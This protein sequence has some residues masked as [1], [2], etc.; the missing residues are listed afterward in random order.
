[1]RHLDV[2]GRDALGLH[3]QPFRGLPFIEAGS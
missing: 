3:L 1:M 2:L